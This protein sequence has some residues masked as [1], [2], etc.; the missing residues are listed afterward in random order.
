MY[1]RESLQ[2]SSLRFLQFVD[3]IFN[4]FVNFFHT[5]LKKKKKTIYDTKLLIYD[6]NNRG[7]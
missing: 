1:N 6:T 3:L 4:R 5:N 7:Y 2:I